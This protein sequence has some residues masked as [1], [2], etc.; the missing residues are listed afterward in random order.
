MLPLHLRRSLWLTALVGAIAITGC[1]AQ[2]SGG[3]AEGS[4]GDGAAA[5]D[6]GGSE[7][8]GGSGGGGELCSILADADVEE[9]TG[10]DVTEGD[11]SEGDCNYTLNEGELLNVR[12]ESSFDPGLETARMI[13]DNA[14]EISGIGDEAIWCP[15][16]NVLYFNKGGQSLAVQLVYILTDPSRPERDIASDVARRIAEGL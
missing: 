14:E 10:A 1:T 3:G 5:T 11:M 15:D 4:S 9:I 6:A 13:C 8:D 7:G 2:Q 12:Y 16:V